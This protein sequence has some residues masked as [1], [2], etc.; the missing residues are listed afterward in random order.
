MLLDHALTF[1]SASIAGSAGLSFAIAKYS[2]AVKPFF[3]QLLSTAAPIT[4]TFLVLLD[5]QDSA[6]LHGGDLLF[7]GAVSALAFG[8]SYGVTR[9]VNPRRRGGL[10]SA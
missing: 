1:A 2:P 6:V 10:P 5:G 8:T 3:R 4:A 7:G 9:L